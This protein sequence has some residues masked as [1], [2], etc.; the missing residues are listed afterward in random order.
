MLIHQSLLPSLRLELFPK[1]T[2][3]V[4]VSV[5]ECDGMEGCV[6]SGSVAASA[7]LADAG[8]EML[9]LVAACSA[10]VLDKERDT[11]AGEPWMDP[12]EEES[13]RSS[14]A[15]VMACMPAL[16]TLTNVS[17]VGSMTASQLSLVRYSFMC[18]KTA[19]LY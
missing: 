11:G 8:I 2:I 16:G 4:F 6:A 14:G 17:Q 13:A 18:V 5:L 7:A 9:G 19:T 12:N 1:S 10:C 15:V 3:D